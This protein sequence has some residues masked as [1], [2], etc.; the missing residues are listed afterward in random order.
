MVEGDIRMNAGARLTRRGVARLAATLV[1]AS[2][3]TAWLTP[4]VAAETV[5]ECEAKIRA[6]RAATGSATFIGRNEE[7]DRAGLLGK[8]KSA[9][10][11]LAQGKFE[12]AVLSLTQFR[13]KVISL[14]SQGK[15][16]PGDA[17]ALITRADDA[18][19]CVQSLIV[20]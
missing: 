12:D 10:E 8:L 6:L 20:A 17:N 11:K 15:I 4:G 19:A 1:M 16:D 13:G 9:S 2:M 18:I 14:Q 5:E 7:K 3:G